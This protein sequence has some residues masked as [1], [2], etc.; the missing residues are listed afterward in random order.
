LWDAIVLKY[1]QNRSTA[2]IASTM[3]EMFTKKW[4]SGNLEQHIAWFR[5][6]NRL[7][8]RFDPGVH[9]PQQQALPSRSTCWQ[10]R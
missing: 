7:L 5:S 1:E 8:A 9:L 2:A 3:Q 6:T 10:S 4:D